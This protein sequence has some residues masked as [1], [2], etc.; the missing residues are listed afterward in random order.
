MKKLL[1]LPLIFNC[2][3]LSAQIK[4][5][6]FEKQ[7]NW[8]I[9][10]SKDY[11]AKIDSTQ[12][13]SG[14]SSL[15]LDKVNTNAKGVITFSQSVP[16]ITNST[17][18]INISFYVKT[19]KIEESAA[20]W[21]QTRSGNNMQLS[22]TNSEMQGIVITGTNDWRKY[23]LY[24]IVP[25]E[26]TKLIIGGYH[27]SYGQVWFDDIS[28]S[29]VED[30]NTKDNTLI[31]YGNEVKNYI[32]NNSI[33]RD[34]I[35]WKQIDFDLANITNK[36][37]IEQNDL[38]NQYFLIQ[39]R[40]AGDNH[41]YFQNKIQAKNYS[42]KDVVY[43]QPTAKLINKNIGYIMIPGF[44]STNLS[45]MNK[46]ADTIQQL[47]RKL[48]NENSIKG[49]V[50]DLRANGGGNMHPMIAGLG[51]L[52][53]TGNLGYFIGKKSTAWRYKKNGVS[54]NVK[55]KNPYV[56]KNQMSKIA[57]LV[58]PNT[59]SSGEMTAISF[60]GKE[61]VKLFGHPTGG[62][63]T[64]NASFSLSN[65]G[66]LFLASGYVSDRNKNKFLSKITP[67]VIVEETKGVNL[68]IETA[69]NW[70]LK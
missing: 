17:K 53:G 40:F 42:S 20:I 27:K 59:A 51:P 44:G 25:K 50:I 33:Y 7:E 65:G 34:S 63:L 29:D 43:I 55:V 32:K 3:C 24:L 47:I 9:S 15:K 39:L 45:V 2:I 60:I 23:N 61:N 35:N 54:Q 31:A 1:L 57:V 68:A 67:D 6:S 49:W 70:I 58:C 13:K 38:L 52:T 26:T 66:V 8:I 22:F 64:A 4:N 21:C 56:L 11:I 14:L 62:Y 5:P 19:A 10:N 18:I 12:K 69:V 16:F 41:S 46:F 30:Q 28:I 37:G 48:D 36:I